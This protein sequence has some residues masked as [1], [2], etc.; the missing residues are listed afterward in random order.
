MCAQRFDD[1]VEEIHRSRALLLTR[2]PAAQAVEGRA[3]WRWAPR[4]G[5]VRPGSR[6]H[7]NDVILVL[8]G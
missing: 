8:L 1:V 3:N 2:T 6:F 5:S 4:S 7:S